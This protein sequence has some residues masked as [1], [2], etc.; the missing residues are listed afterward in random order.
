M[1]AV[2]PMHDAFR[3]RNSDSVKIDGSCILYILAWEPMS[4]RR[5]V[6]RAFVSVMS[7]M[8]GVQ[9]MNKRKLDARSIAL[10]AIMA[11]A[12]C[13]F[14]LLIR[15][16]IAPTRGYIHLGD[17]AANFSALA[18]GPWFG[19]VIAGG[20]TALADLIGGYPNWAPLTFVIH[21]LQGFVVGYIAYLSRHRTWPMFLGAALGEVI[22]VVGYFLAEWPL[23]GLGPA[24]TELPGNMIQGLFGLLGVPLF[25]LVARAYPPLLFYGGPRA[26]SDND[27]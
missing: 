7:T 27:R 2:A 1:A 14:T 26:G 21:G 17:V 24:L 9:P 15:I 13:V 25:I 20:G 11:A 16:P 22:V 18:F 8:E 12:T 4:L 23:Y 19:L 10:L 3:R 6:R 5:I